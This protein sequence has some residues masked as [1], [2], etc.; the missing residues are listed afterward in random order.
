MCELWYPHN[1]VGYIYV[2]P[3]LFVVTLFLLLISFALCPIRSMRP[4]WL[5]Y[6]LQWRHNEHDSVS[7]H[8]RFGCLLSRYQAQIKEN[9]N[10]GLCK[11]NSPVTGEFPAKGPVTRKVFPFD[12]VIMYSKLV[13]RCHENTSWNHNSAKS[14]IHNL[15]RERII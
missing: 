4:T 11:E 6:T 7:N 5:L 3:S 15:T 13:S 14:N 12:D 9:I 2:I 8:Q 1:D 10:G